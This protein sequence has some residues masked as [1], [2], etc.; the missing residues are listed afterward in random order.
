MIVYSLLAV[1]LL[2]ACFSLLM[3]WQCKRYNGVDVVPQLLLALS[4]AVFIHLYGTWV[5]VTI[6][7]RYAFD[8]CFVA[9]LVYALIMDR[10][11]IGGR[12]SVWGRLLTATI[13]IIMSVLYFTGTTGKPFGTAQL[14]L[15]FKWGT[16]LVFQGGKGLPTNLFHYKLRTAVYAIDL[17]KLNKAG[18]RAKHVF[19]ANLNDYEI[20]NDTLYSPC[21]GIVAKIND[22]NPDNIPPSR[23]RGP[24][25]T[26]YILLQTDDIYVF[27]GHLIPASMLVAAGE[28]VM[29]GQPIARCGNSGFSLEP[30]LHIQAHVK[31]N[32][33]LPWYKE[34]PLLITFNGKFYR[35]FD[36]IRALD[37]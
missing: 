18:N 22:G 29:A 20:Y 24:S 36:E 1:T 28:H 21:S 35:L 32:T 5:F 2:F 10:T 25:N 3:A 7:A 33:G 6:Y 4:S 27:M 8:I 19:S 23:Q 13:F 34:Q 15:P 16:Y 26:N 11:A 17:V 31:T 37:K 14:A 30:H 12:V 9:V